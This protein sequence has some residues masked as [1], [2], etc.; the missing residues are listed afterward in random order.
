MQSENEKIIKVDIE[1]QMK[2]AYIDY[3]MNEVISLD[4]INL[5]NSDIKITL[6]VNSDIQKYVYEI[7]KPKFWL[8][9]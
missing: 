6:N 5:T 2:S 1:T 7:C 4:N 9:R 8:C 3:A